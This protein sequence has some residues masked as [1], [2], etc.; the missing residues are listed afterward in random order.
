M[1]R[2]CGFCWVIKTHDWDYA[3]VS[4]KARK[5]VSGF[6]SKALRGH[7]NLSLIFFTNS[8]YNDAAISSFP[9]HDCYFSIFMAFQL[10]VIVYSRITPPIALFRRRTYFIPRAKGHWEDT[11]IDWFLGVCWLRRLRSAHFELPR[12]RMVHCPNLTHCLC[13]AWPGVHRVWHR[14]RKV[15]DF[16]VWIWRTQ[17]CVLQLIL[18]LVY[19]VSRY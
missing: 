19:C 4:A 10:F 9:T 6:Y 1:V 12:L 11:G 7:R 13:L 5:L 3:A 8:G 15:L 18:L 2:T 17:F 16:N 14:K